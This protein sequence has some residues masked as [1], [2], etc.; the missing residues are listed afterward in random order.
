[1]AKKAAKKAAK[2]PARAAKRKAISLHL[3]L[4]SVDPAHYAGWDGPLA[5]C[6]FDARDM[7]ALARVRKMS[8]AVLLTSEATR[9]RVL[10]AIRNAARQLK[11]GDLFF[12]T[13]SGHGG[14]VEDTSGDEKDKKDETWCLFDAQLIDDELYYE[15]SRFAAGV[16]ILVLSDSCHSGTVTREALPLTDP[17]RPNARSRFM[18]PAIAR[19]TYAANKAFYDE[20]QAEV[21]RRA[22][23]VAVADPDAALAEVAA[24]SRL[25]AVVKKFKPAKIL[26][27]GC[28]DNQTSMDGERNG[29]FTE[30]LLQVWN[31]GAFTGNYAQFHAQIKQR[32]PA[33]QTPNFFVLGRAGRFARA[34][35]FSG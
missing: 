27:S 23:K 22:G 34:T 19:R 18:P 30:Q 15:Y 7:A 24:S 16:R 29:A 4:N 14:Q 33:T 11:K 25:T 26:I 28:Q 21:K 2:K 8:P 9:D 35:P 17:A 12:L 1:M 13:F 32:L 20:L 31:S 10:K 5:A 6:E 3:G